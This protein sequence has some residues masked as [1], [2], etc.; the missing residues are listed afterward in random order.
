[1]SNAA[2]KK[3]GYAQKHLLNVLALLIL[4]VGAACLA[5]P[6][7]SNWMLHQAQ[8]QV[9]VQQTE[10][11][12]KADPQNLDAEFQNAQHY[13]DAVF[14]GRTVVTDPFDPSQ[15]TTKSDDYLRILNIANDGVMG[16]IHIPKLALS[17]PLYHGTNEDE[18]THGVGHLV[19]T[20]LPIGGPSTHCVFA[21]HTGLPS[22]KIFD[23]LDKLS[24]GDIFII[25]VLKEKRAYEIYNTEI[26]LPHETDSLTIQPDSD[27]VTLVTCTP[28]GVNDHR[29]LVHAKRCE[30]PTEQ[31][32]AVTETKTN[33]SPWMLDLEK[34]TL[35][36][37]G[38][39]VV[40]IATATAAALI[41]RRRRT[42]KDRHAQ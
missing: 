29:F 12:E 37:I 8:E 2:N 38:I 32:E 21:G 4:L 14:A 22:V 16:S 34:P 27:L 11:V 10:A 15:P 3:R 42:R 19:N 30:M 40:I 31:T 17:F 28:Y 1:M 7:V 20:S 36:A 13:N 23:S 25:E 6:T 18:L 9:T 5:Y 26:V 39:F 33:T 41:A 24:A 35:I